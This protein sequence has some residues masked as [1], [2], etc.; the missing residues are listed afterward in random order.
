MWWESIGNKLPIFPPEK[1]VVDRPGKNTAKLSS[2]D[3]LVISTTHNVSSKL[4]QAAAKIIR[5][6]A[7]QVPEEDEDQRLT[8]ETITFLLEDTHTPS[9]YRNKTSVELAGGVFYVFLFCIA[10][11]VILGTLKNL[12]KLEQA[13]GTLS[14]VFAVEEE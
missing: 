4:C 13:L 11:F 5:K 9:S 10:I 12:K 3:N 1:Q 6:A 14:N 2:L 7:Q 8:M